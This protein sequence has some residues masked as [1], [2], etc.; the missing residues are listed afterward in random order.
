MGTFWLKV[1]G[2]ALCG[3]VVVA[4]IGAVSSGNAS[5]SVTDRGATPGDTVG[6]AMA[7]PT[8]GESGPVS[9][10]N[11]ALTQSTP[12]IPEFEFDVGGR[13]PRAACMAWRLSG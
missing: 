4:V 6:V 12:N 9:A 7:K 11:A 5:E 10:R 8:V 2:I 1:A 3:F 13:P